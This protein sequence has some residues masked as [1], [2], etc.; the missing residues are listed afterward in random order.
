L[1]RIDKIDKLLRLYEN[2][3]ESAEADAA[4]KKAAELTRTYID[5]GESPSEITDERIRALEKREKE[6]EKICRGCGQEKPLHHKD[7]LS[8]QLE[9]RVGRASAAGCFSCA[10]IIVIWFLS[11]F[12]DLMMKL[13]G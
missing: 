2:N 7:C 9:K 5:S 13:F 10:G 1:S 3:P 12:I 4:L 8:Y 11:A 6:L